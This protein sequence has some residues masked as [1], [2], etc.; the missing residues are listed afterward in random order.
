MTI[1][2]TAS[3]SHGVV[4]DGVDDGHRSPFATAPAPLATDAVPVAPTVTGILMVGWTLAGSEPRCS[5]DDS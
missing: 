3:G 2:V 1:T 5:G 4:A